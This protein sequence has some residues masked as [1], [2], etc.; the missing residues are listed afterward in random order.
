MY[1]S[2]MCTYFAYICKD[3]KGYRHVIKN[4]SRG[5]TLSNFFFFFLIYD[6]ISL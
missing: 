2:Y 1:L 5:S 6:L 3:I 4:I